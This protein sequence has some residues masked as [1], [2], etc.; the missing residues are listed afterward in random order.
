MVLK[1]HKRNKRKQ[2]SAWQKGNRRVGKL[3]QVNRRRMFL[4]RS[5]GRSEK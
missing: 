1:K 3:P 5:Y 2:S 4:R